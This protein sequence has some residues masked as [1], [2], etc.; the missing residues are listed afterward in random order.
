MLFSEL[1]ICNIYIYIMI[2]LDDTSILIA[3]DPLYM[4]TSYLHTVTH[5]CVILVVETVVDGSARTEIW[6]ADFQ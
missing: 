6:R 1:E 3:K 4:Y 2:F 5:F